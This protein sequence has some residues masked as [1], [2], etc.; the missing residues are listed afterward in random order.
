MC[1]DS[2]LY[3]V[4][5]VSLLVLCIIYRLY[6]T[7]DYFLLICRT[8]GHKSVTGRSCDRPSRHRFFLV[9]LGPRAN[10]GMVPVFF[11]S[12][13]PLHASHVALPQTK[14]RVIN[15]HRPCICNMWNDHCHRVAT[16][17]QLINIIIIRSSRLIN[18]IIFLLLLDQVE[19]QSW[20]PG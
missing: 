11:L 15:L 10:T 5:F 16:N 3:C 20:F 1:F 7:P 8:A 19:K 2:L 13:L 4:Y 14:S 17:L 18:I 6:L 9:F 12:K